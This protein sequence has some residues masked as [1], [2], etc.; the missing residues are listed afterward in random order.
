MDLRRV[1]RPRPSRP[2]LVAATLAVASAAVLERRHLRA[3]AAD[4][5]FRELSAPLGG[6]AMAPITSADGTVLYAERFGGG[7]ADPP[8]QATLVLA[9]GW[10]ERITWW[11]PVIRRLAS[12][13]LAV[14]AFDLRGHGDSGAAAGGD[15]ALERVGEDIEAV[16]AAAGGPPDRTALAGHSLG[17]M[18]IAAW[19][20]GFPVAERVAA[21]ALVNTGLSDLIG[22][23]LIFGAVGARLAPEWLG[24]ALLGSGRPLLPVSTPLTQAAARH[25]AFGP[26]A[27][28]GAVAFYERMLMETDPSARAA[29]GIAL[30]TLDL[31][32]A[33]GRITVPTL[34]VCGDR[35]RLTPPAH[36]RAIHEALPHPAGLLELTRTGHMAA[37][38]R[39]DELA[40]AL[41]ELLAATGVR[42]PAQPVTEVPNG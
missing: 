27:S 28:R 12:P 6:R 16:L 14:V 21:A 39:P 8:R 40:A 15:Y 1:P 7:N 22:G 5:D 31:S 2:A 29:V 33:V 18:S 10:T 37:L 42:T 38:E 23:A 32:A 41:H 35:D 26:D 36:A 24:R 19:A 30:S 11:A 34:V 3:I 25:T 4:P 17:A 13:E 20:A 9:H